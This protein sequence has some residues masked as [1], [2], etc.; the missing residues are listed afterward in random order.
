MY[1][2]HDGPI[3]VLCSDSANGALRAYK[4]AVVINGW[5]MQ[6]DMR[7]VPFGVNYL[8]GFLSYMILHELMH[9]ADSLQCEWSHG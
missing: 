7:L 3:I 9:A 1:P 2:G 6:G 4:E 8:A 5:N